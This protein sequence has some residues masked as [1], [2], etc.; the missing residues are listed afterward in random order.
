MRRKPRWIARLLPSAELSREVL[1]LAAPVTLGTLTFTLLTVVDTAMLGRLGAVPLAASGVAGVLFFAV[2]FPI[3]GVSIGVQT[4]V[5][6][7]FGEGNAARC[8]EVFNT[9][10]LLAVALGA[11]LVIAAPW[12][13]RLFAALSSNDPEVLAASD[14]YLRY[15]F[16][17]TVFMM[18]N[19]TARAFFAGIGRTGHQF[20]GAVLT[21]AANILFDYLLIFGRGGFPQLGIQGAA[22]ASTIALGVGALYYTSVLMIGPDYRRRFAVLRRPWFS[23]AWLKPIVRLSIPVV[24]QRLT[25][26]GA[27]SIFFLI[28]ARIGTV[29]LAA[30]NVIRSIYHLTIMIGVGLGT[31]A[32]AL[33]GQN[34][35]AKDPDRAEALGWEAVRLATWTMAILGMLF[36]FAPG[37]VFRIYTSDAAVIGVGRAALMLLGLVQGFAG[38]ALVLT[39]ALQGAGNTRYVMLVEF[40]CVACYLPTVYLLGLRAGLGLVGAW[41]GEY[42]YWLLLSA[43]VAW[44]Y[45][46][47]NWKRIVV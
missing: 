36:L 26:N 10:I 32:A 7:R 25:S 14:V 38:I 5:A 44:K 42:I 3:S 1:R 29:E 8:G 33:I 11:P 37:W 16:L 22:I 20:V 31:A 28:V 27:W 35:G 6:R 34:L 21:T 23:Q 18:I 24:L 15:R 13:A 47:G 41:T 45:R 30:S 4:L 9:G 19:F 40:A 2:T 12:L 43:A 46:S 17:G 39:Q